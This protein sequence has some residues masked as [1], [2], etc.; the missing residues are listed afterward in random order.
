MNENYNYI[1]PFEVDEEIIVLVSEITNKLDSNNIIENSK[2]I[3][4]RKKNRL[5]SLQS[6]LAIENNSLSLKQVTDIIE[7]K[8]VIGKV[9][10]IKEVKNIYSAYENI[11]KYDQYDINDLLKAHKYITSE[12]VSQSGVFRSG[13]V[14][15][16]DSNGNVVH[17]GARPEYIEQEVIKLFRWLKTSNTHPLI[18]SCVF[19]F[20]IEF[21]HPFEDGNGRI[22]RLWQTLMLSKYNKTFECM[23]I[24]TIIHNNQRK[25]YKALNTSSNS[26]NSTQFIKFML[27]VILESF[28]SLNDNLN[29]IERDVLSLIE[30]NKNITLD[31]LVKETK[32]SKR[33]ISRCV[34][35]LKEK[36][37]IRRIG[38]DKNGYWEI[39]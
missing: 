26:N 21:I 23:P 35:S 29:D 28:D 6:T 15:I 14:G 20:E 12:L 25:Y 36:N 22:G 38:S 4:L 30:G 18:K 16:Y 5:M 9:K 10:E 39:I 31:L 34:K 8:R 24:E 1:P 17:M 11:N 13:D 37:N 27:N 2:N 7:G 19:H 33:T 32:K 3:K